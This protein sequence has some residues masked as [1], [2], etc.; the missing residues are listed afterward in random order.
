M[1]Q[2]FSNYEDKVATISQQPETTYSFKHLFIEYILSTQ[3]LLDVDLVQVFVSH[4]DK[5]SVELGQCQDLAPQNTDG[6]H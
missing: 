4:L 5:L 2:S 6:V 3:N 1:V